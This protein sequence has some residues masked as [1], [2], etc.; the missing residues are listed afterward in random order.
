M[1]RY[2][3]ENFGDVQDHLFMKGLVTA[4]YSEDDTVDLTISGGQDGSGIPLFYHCEPDSVER[5]NGAIE[6]AAKAFNVDDEV[7]VM[8]TVDGTPVRVVGLVDG[9]K[10]CS[11]GYLLLGAAAFASGFWYSLWDIAEEKV[12]DDIVYTDDET[13]VETL[14]VF[15][16]L[17]DLAEPVWSL[18]PDAPPPEPNNDPLYKW[19]MTRPWDPELVEASRHGI[20][21][22]AISN[23]LSF[24]TGAKPGQ[25]DYVP[26]NPSLG[27]YWVQCGTQPADSG[28]ASDTDSVP[29]RYQW[30]TVM[31][32]NDV[33]MVS[34]SGSCTSQIKPGYHTTDFSE[35]HNRVVWAAVGMA[36]DMDDKLFNTAPFPSMLIARDDAPGVYVDYCRSELTDSFDSDTV[37]TCDHDGGPPCEALATMDFTDTYSYAFETPLGGLDSVSF[38]TIFGS[39]S[40]SCGFPGHGVGCYAQGVN[41]TSTGAE[42][43]WGG[44]PG[45]KSKGSTQEGY[46]KNCRFQAYYYSAAIHSKTYTNSVDYEWVW[47]GVFTDVV[48]SVEFFPDGDA[49]EAD[50]LEAERHGDFTE[51]ISAL[52]TH[53]MGASTAEDSSVRAFWITA[54][55]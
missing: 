19:L 50:A 6:E 20:P 38:Q 53:T 36:T 54:H 11:S 4:V 33:S 17:A 12:A 7:I 1:P 46:V 37:Y 43:E 9:I 32:F 13:G 23:S 2:E 40:T 5:G 15:P 26:P 47:S 16:M 48:A 41:E 8:C 35:T 31:G 44:T 55:N 39:A 51:A 24:F 52:F 49:E 45:A 42:P 18:D 30:G 14:F 34:Q 25:P 28:S 29:T 3:H 22:N 10:E 27:D 21:G